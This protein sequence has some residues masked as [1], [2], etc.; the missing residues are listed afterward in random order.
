MS[1]LTVTRDDDSGRYEIREGDALA[2][3]AEFEQGEGRVQFTRTETDP[4]FRG[5]GIGSMLVSEALA[6]VA[7]RG[8][9]IVPLCSFVA[10]YLRENE[11][12]GAI[13]DWPDGTPI[14]AATPGEQPA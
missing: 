11:V 14:D 2:G 13:V 7:Q 8:D 6:D 9:V 5:R 10:A 12:A 1:D 4:A 3:F